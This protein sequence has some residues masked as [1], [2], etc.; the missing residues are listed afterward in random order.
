[1]KQVTQNYKTG[2][3]NV[4]DVERPALKT[5]GVLVRTRYSVVSTGTEGMKVRE[6][7]LSYLG[8]AR[9]RPDQLKKVLDSVR[10][11]GV[12][13]TYRKVMNK[14]DALTPL[15]YSLSGEVIAVGEG[16]EEF[17]VGQRVACAGAGYANHAE[18][19]FV[20][21]NLVVPVPTNVSLPHA[22]FATVGAIALQSFRQ[23]QMQLGESACVIG[24]GL[25]G[26][27]LVQLLRAAGVQVVGVDLVDSRCRLAVELGAKW[28]TTPTDVTLDDAI[29]RL[30][31][32]Y[33]VDCAFIAA[34]S[35]S[36]A[37][38]ELA[39]R[40]VRDRARIV[41]V[42]KARLDLPWNECYLKELDV[43]FSRS[44]G[45]GRYD[46]VYEERGIDYPLG[47]VR[48][49]ERRNLAAF[50][51]LVEEGKV[52]LDP[53]IS[54][55]RPFAEAERVYEELATP[56]AEALGIVLDYGSGPDEPGTVA[57]SASRSPRAASLRRDRLGLGVIGAGNYASSMLLPHL[58][59]HR[60]IDLI[61]VATATSLSAENAKR[62][63]G[64]VEATT[65]YRALLERED[66]Q[67]VLIATR[68][69]THAR[70]VAEA[71]RAGKAVYV[72]KPL[73]ITLDGLE[74]VRTAVAESGNDR[75]MVGFNRRFSPMVQ[76]MAEELRGGGFPLVSHYRVHAGRIERG[77][78]Y[79]DPSEG[80]RFVG[81]AGHF[82]DVLGYLAAAR[83][84]SITAT[85]LRPPKM[86]PD[87]LENV[88]A[89]VRYDNGAVANVMYLTQGGGKLPKEYLEAHGGGMTLQLQNFETL[90]R[91]DQHR[92]RRLRSG[93]IDKGQ[94][95]E[96]AAFVEAVHTGAAMPIP[97]DSLFD[98]T[99][100]TL[101]AME[102]IR[103]GREVVLTGYLESAEETADT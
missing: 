16:A 82:F 86:T 62:K 76:A 67:A 55:V 88:T 75:L 72:E 101:A 29:A 78:W 35:T 45:P 7:K 85:A 66:V 48:W 81:E 14:L 36:N 31:D 69:A 92:Q 98:T 49:T 71:L 84:V 46:P 20:P 97:L 59:R 41:D 50:L 15:G 51:D 2:T 65:N 74:T 70:I 44:Y 26:Q 63:F 33:G 25:L 93:V 28:A 73:A 53:I 11:Q 89:V 5:G 91:F 39:V 13:A 12:M 47:Y 60:Q 40:V 21:R 61:S 94:A 8:K 1:M 37:A 103:T 42:G 96:L 56:G 52:R 54:G 17:H 24:L 79:L 80:S 87:D 32:G 19:N 34:G 18:I 99:L 64:F 27:L 95:N 10:Q 22:A 58:T 4:Q 100:T 6:G 30:T 9:A 23:A 90:W 3:I 57:A 38:T 68:H 77:S 83:P 43:R 102:S